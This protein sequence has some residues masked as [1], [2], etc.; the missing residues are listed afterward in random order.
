[1]SVS[2]RCP[3]CDGK[4]ITRSSRELSK[5]MRE[6]FY[7][8]MTPECGHTYVAQLEIVRTLSPSAQPNPAIELP[9]SPVSTAGRQLARNP[10]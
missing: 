9:F 7:M 8:C 4:S 6:I 5:T 1:M 10:G 2:I 3:H